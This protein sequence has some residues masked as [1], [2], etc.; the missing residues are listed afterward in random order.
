MVEGS[1]G[2][3]A[4]S[5]LTGLSMDTL[6]WYE[7]EGLLPLV[8]RDPDGRRA[9][10]PA[11]V[12]FVRLVQALR[13]T[14]MPVDD[15]RAFVRMGPG[16]EWHEKRAALLEEHAAN[17]ERR[18]ERLRRDLAVVRDKIGHHRELERRGLDCEDEIG[19]EDGHA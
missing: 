12:R 15:V 18:I 1:V 7:R 8:E 2:I 3:R 17:V 11:A 6:R 16:L 13:G 19:A 14:G 4:V 9:Y 10:P 5:E